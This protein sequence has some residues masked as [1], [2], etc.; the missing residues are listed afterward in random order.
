[1]IRSPAC[2]PWQPDQPGFMPVIVVAS[3][4]LHHLTAHD[5]AMGQICCREPRWERI[6]GD[7][8]RGAYVPNIP[9]RVE[10]PGLNEMDPQPVIELTLENDVLVAREFCPQEGGVS[11]RC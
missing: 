8:N 3:R 6:G 9:S 5:R 1:M 4:Q 11:V 2:P 7:M 10:F